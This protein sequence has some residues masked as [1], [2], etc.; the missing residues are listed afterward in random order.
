MANLWYRSE[1]RSLPSTQVLKTE[2]HKHKKNNVITA[3]Q[4]PTLRPS[5]LSSI[6]ADIPSF[7][8]LRLS[9]V[10]SKKEL[11]GGTVSYR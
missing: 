7:W 5:A 9:A 2:T 1:S 10:A 11:A 8:S 4:N 6:L 3:L